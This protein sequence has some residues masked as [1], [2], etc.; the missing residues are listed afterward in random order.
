MRRPCCSRLAFQIW[1]HAA[2]RQYVVAFTSLLVVLSSTELQK[3]Q[4]LGATIGSVGWLYIRLSFCFPTRSVAQA[5][6]GAGPTDTGTWDRRSTVFHHRFS[7][8]GASH[9]HC[10]GLNTWWESRQIEGPSLPQHINAGL[11]QL[12]QRDGY[13]SLAEAVGSAAHQPPPSFS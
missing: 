10:S 13:A 5:P 4:V 9:P 3:G 8:G 12:L 1:P 11:M 2:Q 7:V 6:L